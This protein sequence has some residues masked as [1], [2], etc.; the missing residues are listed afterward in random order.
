MQEDVVGHLIAAGPVD[1]EGDGQATIGSPSVD[2]LPM[3]DL[4]STV[5]V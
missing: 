1:E 5:P 2:G 3:D 4:P